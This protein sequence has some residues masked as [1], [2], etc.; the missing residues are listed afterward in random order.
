MLNAGIKERKGD[1]MEKNVR[2]RILLVMELIVERTDEE[3]GVTMQEILQW[4]ESNQIAGERKSIYE[5]I[6]ALQQ[7]GLNITYNKE[8]KTYRLVERQMDTEELA[9]LIQ[10]VRA[11]D[12]IPE[13]KEKQMIEHL[14][15]YVS[16]YQ[17]QI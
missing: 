17:R 12:F 15:N 14:M 16:V 9:L 4:L 3:H 13:N 7:Y 6:H 2:L 5:D 11:A 1:T 8:D 10:A